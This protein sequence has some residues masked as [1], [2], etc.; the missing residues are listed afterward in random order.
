[1]PRWVVFGVPY[2]WGNSRGDVLDLRLDLAS[3][4]WVE[5]VSELGFYWVTAIS[6]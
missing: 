5:M 1:M 2:L 6:G 4:L 3:D